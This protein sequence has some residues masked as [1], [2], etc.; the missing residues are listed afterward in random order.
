MNDQEVKTLLSQI[1]CPS[2][3]KNL[4]ILQ[5]QQLAEEI[6]KKIICTVSEK[7]GHLAPNLGVV[8]LTIALHYVFDTAADRIIWDVGHQAYTHKLLTGRRSQFHTLRQ[9]QGISGFPKRS[10]SKFDAFGTGH[11]GTS[12][13]AALGISVAKDLKKSPHRAIAVIGDGSMTGGMAFE[14]LNHAGDVNKNLIVVLNDNEMSISPNVGALSSFLSRKLSNKTLINLK[15]DVENFLK[16]IPGLGPNIIQILKRS[17]DSL[18]TLLTPGMLFQALDFH[19]IGPIKGHRLDRLIE[20]F[21][22]ARHIQGPVL[23]HVMTQKGKGYQPAECDPTSFH[24]VGSFDISTGKSCSSP[25]DK[26]CAPSYTKVFGDSIVQLAESD[27]KVLAI[28]AAMPQGTGLEAFAKRFPDRFFDVGIAEQHAVTFA[29]GLATEGFKPVVA[30]YSTFLQRAYDQIVHDVCLQNLHV[31]FAM[32]RGGIVGE[33]GPTHHGVFDLSF[34]RHIP[35]MV[36]MAPKDENELQHMLKTAVEHGGPVAVRYPRGNGLGVTMDAIPR[37]LPVGK[38]EV[39]REGEDILLLAVGSTVQA[40]VVAA[41]RLQK[42]GV[43]AAVINARFV[44][45]VDQELILTWAKK[46]GRIITIEEN[47]LQG[48]F[49]SA[50]LEMLQEAEYFPRNFVRLGLP[51]TFVPHGSQSILRNLYG[52]DAEGI[53]NA[54]YSALKRHHVQALSAIG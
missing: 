40:A 46:T 54:A 3:L 2:Q 13:S 28:T 34:L 42:S 43:R 12:I 14:A 37:R 30:V 25:S 18:M 17:E 35:N 6:R 33:D 8:E 4:S 27:P 53:E 32:D 50:V 31:I 15:K 52:I 48:G 19:Y 22:T 38:G 11:S 1:D 41:E 49:G 23:I 26:V 21:E 20:T 44:K 9:Y 39:L 45:P 24:G 5:L 47:V 10:E 16:S 29:A 51:D 7:G 36:V